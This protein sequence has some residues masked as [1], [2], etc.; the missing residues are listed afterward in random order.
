MIVIILI[1]NAALARADCT[2][3]TARAVIRQPMESPVC[4][5]PALW[6][7]AQTQVAPQPDEY[8]LIICAQRN[9]AITP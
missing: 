6:S 2:Q 8:P 3:E 4:A 7:F 5:G 1:C 9:D